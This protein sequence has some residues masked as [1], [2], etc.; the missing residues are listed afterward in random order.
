MAAAGLLISSQQHRVRR[1]QEHDLVIRPLPLERLQ[2]FLQ[3]FEEVALPDIHD[4]RGL[5]DAGPAGLG[6]A[7]ELSDQAGRHVVDAVVAQVFHAVDGLGFA[8]AG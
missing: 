4:E 1:L 3:V 6:Q 7:Q 5:V 8:C 2:A